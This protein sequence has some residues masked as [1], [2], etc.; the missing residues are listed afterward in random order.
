MVSL[1]SLQA[2]FDYQKRDKY[3]VTDQSWM[4]TQ[5]RKYKNGDIS[6]KTGLQR[7]GPGDWREPNNSY[8]HR[9]GSNGKVVS[10]KKNYV[11]D[12]IKKHYPEGKPSLEQLAADTGSTIY[13]PQ[14]TD[15]L[16]RFIKAGTK[17]LKFLTGGQFNAILLTESKTVMNKEGTELDEGL[18][19]RTTIAQVNSDYPNVMMINTKHP[20]WKSKSKR[21]EILKSASTNHKYHAFFHEMGHMTYSPKRSLTKD[22]YDTV[23]SLSNVSIQSA[24]EYCAEY[25][26]RTRLGYATTKAQDDLFNSLTGGKE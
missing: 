17:Y 4:E 21:E 23:K 20:Y 5:D 12:Y 2:A 3:L 7:F 8:E 22:D 14:N 10:K 16:S 11:G 1:N 24:A 25:Y 15:K 13:N 26:A 18:I 6:E 19:A 9:M